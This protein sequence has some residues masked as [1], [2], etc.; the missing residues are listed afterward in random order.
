VKGIRFPAGFRLEGL[1]HNHDRR[2]FRCGENAVE[3]WLASKALQHQEKHLSATK[4]LLDAQN[5]ITGYYTLAT[6]QVDFS[7]LPTDLRRGLPRR[8][9]PV[10]ILAW[11]AVGSDRQGQGLGTYL[12]AQALRDCYEAGKTFAFVAVLLECIN[13]AAKAFY[14]KR[15]FKEVPGRPYRLYLSAKRLEAMMRPDGST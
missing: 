6:G 9:L 5:K 8:L 10:A 3:E 4:V 14:L 15:E 1:R 7:D 11:F 13:D 12:L 2:S